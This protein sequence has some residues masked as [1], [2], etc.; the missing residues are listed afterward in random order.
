MLKFEFTSIL[1]FGL[2]LGVILII[3]TFQGAGS[4]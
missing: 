4:F 3:K 1:F 2:Y